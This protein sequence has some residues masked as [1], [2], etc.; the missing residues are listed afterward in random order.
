MHFIAA[1]GKPASQVLAAQLEAGPV[2]LDAGHEDGGFDFQGSASARACSLII[3]N[4]SSG[5]NVS[6]SHLIITLVEGSRYD[7]EQHSR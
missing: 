6:L 5:G 2:R 1:A 7:G 4:G 3:G